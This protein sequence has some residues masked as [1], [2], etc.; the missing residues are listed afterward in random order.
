MGVNRRTAIVT[1]SVCGYR[2]KALA[3]PKFPRLYTVAGNKHRGSGRS[4][5]AAAESST[6]VGTN[7]L[8]ANTPEADTV[9]NNNAAHR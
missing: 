7:K 9:I 2:A 1:G 8:I 4:M 3:N 6:P 5:E